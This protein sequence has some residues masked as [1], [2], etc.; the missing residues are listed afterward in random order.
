MNRTTVIR[1][2]IY[3]GDR[4]LRR[5]AAR[6][7]EEFREARRD[8]G[9]SQA[10]V[11]RAIG[12]GRSTICRMEAGHAGVAPRVRARAAAMVGAEFR[13]V[14]Y[15]TSAPLIVDAAQARIVE[16][17]IATCHP[18]WRAIVEAPVPGPGHRSSDIRLQRCNDVVLVEVVSHVGR[19]EECIRELHQKREAVAAS[20]PL[21]CACHVLLVL[22][23]TQHHRALA[24]AHPATIEA[25][26]PAPAHALRE[27]LT[28][29]DVA[30]PGD[31]ILWVSAGREP[32]LVAP[33]TPAPARQRARP[34]RPSDRPQ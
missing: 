30:W 29:E 14:I 2:A 1:R 28:G 6:F 5:A 24:R 26:F 17:L 22:P 15:R 12:I 32:R 23:A 10:A 18:T 4:Q 20:L 8:T 19:W 3:E 33:T 31:G 7:G 11:A 34:P 25:A 27:A 13:M 9:L 16:M 21:G